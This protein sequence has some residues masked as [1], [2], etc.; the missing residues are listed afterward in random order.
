[1]SGLHNLLGIGKSSLAAQLYGMQVSG[2]NI[3]NVNT[4]G[5]SRQRVNLTPS[6]S[7]SLGNN[8]ILGTGVTVAQVQRVRDGLLDIHI[9]SE[10]GSQ[11]RWTSIASTLRELES[12]FDSTSAGTL[13]DKINEFWNSWYDLSN[14][15][16]NAVVKNSVRDQGMMLA[17]NDPT[18]EFDLNQNSRS[19]PENTTV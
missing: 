6:A 9:R 1:M 8:L 11:G 12:L 13:G 3:A 10:N 14:E 17:N 18:G 4:K 5:Y 15:P 7:V 2:N 19:Q 16:E